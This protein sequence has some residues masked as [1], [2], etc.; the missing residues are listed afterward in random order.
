[1]RRGACSFID[2]TE[3]AVDLDLPGHVGGGRVLLTGDEPL[4]HLGARVRIVDIRPV[5]PA[6]GHD[7]RAGPERGRSS[8]PRPRSSKQ[9]GLLDPD[10][11]GRVDPGLEAL[12]EVAC[13]HWGATLPNGRP[14]D[15]AE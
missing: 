2:G 7:D 6:F 12:E 13:G 14:A 8:F 3:V 10:E 5:G 15:P 11:I 1:M 9:V 4:E